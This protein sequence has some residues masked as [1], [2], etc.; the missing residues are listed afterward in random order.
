[1]QYTPRPCFSIF[2]KEHEDEKRHNILLLLKGER[3]FQGI[4]SGD[5]DSSN[6]LWDMREEE[7]ERGQRGEENKEEKKEEDKDEEKEEEFLQAM[8][9]VWRKLQLLVMEL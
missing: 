7:R 4:T 1:M 3:Y 2:R 5:K 6:I 8:T 9:R